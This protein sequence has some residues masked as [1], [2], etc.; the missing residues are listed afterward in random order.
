M[1]LQKCDRKLSD[2]QLFASMIS[3][4][5]EIGS[6]NGLVQRRNSFLEMLFINCQKD[7]KYVLCIESNGQ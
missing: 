5:L 3:K 7:R 2:Y 6:M 1:L 4:K